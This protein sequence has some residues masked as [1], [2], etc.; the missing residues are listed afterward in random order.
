MI[1]QKK[2]VGEIFRG[3]KMSGNG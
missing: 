3:W 1:T 2:V